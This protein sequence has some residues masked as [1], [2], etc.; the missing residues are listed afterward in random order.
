MISAKMKGGKN[1]GLKHR[2]IILLKK[3]ADIET[4]KCLK[5]GILYTFQ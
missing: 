5:Q 4:R 2:N 3:K 1:T